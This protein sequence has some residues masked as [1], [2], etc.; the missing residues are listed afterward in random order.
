MNILNLIKIDQ[1][2]LLLLSI[3]VNNYSIFF[4]NDFFN[5][6]RRNYNKLIF[7]PLKLPM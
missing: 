7:T 5:K 4:N 2:V 6:I 3:K 1:I